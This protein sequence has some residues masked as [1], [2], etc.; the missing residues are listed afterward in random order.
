MPEG[1]QVYPRDR[2]VE[3]FPLTAVNAVLAP[4]GSVM[5]AAKVRDQRRTVACVD[6][7]GRVEPFGLFELR[8]IEEDTV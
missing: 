2:G 7:Y 3:M 8:R 1:Q 5:H 6:V 4:H